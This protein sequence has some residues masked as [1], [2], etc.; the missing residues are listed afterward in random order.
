MSDTINETTPLIKDDRDNIPKSRGAVL[1]SRRWITVEPIIMAVALG[2]GILMVVQ[3]QYVH[4]YFTNIYGGNV[5]YSQCLP[6]ISDSQL[7]VNEEIQAETTLWSI[8]M[9]V[10]VS[11]GSIPVGFVLGSYSDQ[12]GRKIPLGIS[13]SGMFLCSLSSFLT[14]LF[15]LP[16]WYLLLGT[17][18]LGLSGGFM[19]MVSVCMSYAADVTDENNRMI[20]IIVLDVLL[21]LMVGVPQLGIGFLIKNVGYAVPFLI[22]MTVSLLVLAYIIIPGLLLET[23][24]RNVVGGVRSPVKKTFS[25]AMGILKVKENRR[26]IKIILYMVVAFAMTGFGS[27]SFAVTVLYGMGAPLCLSP[28]DIGLFLFGSLMSAGV[29]KYYLSLS[30]FVCFFFL[31]FD[32]LICG[33]KQA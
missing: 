20:H 24:E 29:G 3:S 8:Y 18:I 9:T 22:V 28:E 27:G 13:V 31:N 15:E 7:R 23:V 10:C 1:A 4:H 32:S 26:H 5:S 11:I 14:I 25:D 16:L 21:F 12:I 19:L 33:D 30:L 2:Y 17:G 6:N